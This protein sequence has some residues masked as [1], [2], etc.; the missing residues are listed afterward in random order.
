MQAYTT[1]ISVD[2]LV[3][4]MVSADADNSLI[5]FD[6]RFAL[7]DTGLG[8]NK[9]AI[10]HIPEAIYVDLEHD[11]AGDITPDSG[12]HPLP[13]IAHFVQRL[14]AWG[15][16][17]HTQ[18]VVYDDAAGAIATR[19]WW[20]MKWIGHTRVALLDGGYTAWQ[21]SGQPTSDRVK[22]SIKSDWQAMSSRSENVVL[23]HN[24]NK[25]IDVNELTELLKSQR[26]NLYDARAEAR[27]AGRHE[28]ID[29]VAGH[30]PGA[31]NLPFEQNLD[32]QGF[33]LP[34]DV[35]KRRFQSVLSQTDANDAAIVN[36]CGSGVTACHNALAMEI[37]EVK[38]TR[39]Y[40]GSWSEWIRN[41]D[42]A[43][44]MQ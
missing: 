39:L 19:L 27:F 40:V 20:M 15:V 41:P 34:A 8:R 32:E 33:F 22:T 44:A 1:L 26:I 37:A 21:H 6:C 38:P 43:V 2:Q 23:K 42:R 16:N 11:L 13:E 3:A 28:P 17:N 4:L 35:L 25:V 18:V 29:T 31:V 24:E 5:V 36:M 10:N 30:I 7:M 12:R 14:R 9:Y